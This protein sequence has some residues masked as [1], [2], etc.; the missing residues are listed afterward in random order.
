MLRTLLACF[1]LA[2][3]SSA[4]EFKPLGGGRGLKKVGNAPAA[5]GERCRSGWDRGSDWER[6]FKRL[7]PGCGELELGRPLISYPVF[8][9]LPERCAGSQEAAGALEA[10]WRGRTDRFNY[11]QILLRDVYTQL[12]LAMPEHGLELLGD[13]RAAAQENERAFQLAFARGVSGLFK[14]CPEARAQLDTRPASCPGRD[15]NSADYRDRG[16]RLCFQKLP[17]ESCLSKRMIEGQRLAANDP[18]LNRLKEPSCAQERAAVGDRAG[19]L[20]N[21]TPNQST[22]P[23]SYAVDPTCRA[24]IDHADRFKRACDR[25]DELFYPQLERLKKRCVAAQ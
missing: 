15:A 5:S 19:Y 3:S 7:P 10:E 8:G 25:W 6:M 4:M 1:C 11:G 22:I 2:V 17:E 16:Q 9:A 24:V 14:A 18:S 20:V 21:A 23:V 12:V 13:F